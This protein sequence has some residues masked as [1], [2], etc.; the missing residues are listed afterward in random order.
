MHH[1]HHEPLI[2]HW[3]T[4]H[5]KSADSTLSLSAKFLSYYNFQSDVL[6]ASLPNKLQMRWEIKVLG[7]CGHKRQIHRDSARLGRKY[8]LFC[9]FKQNRKKFPGLSLVSLLFFCLASL[10]A[11]AYRFSAVSFSSAAV[12][13]VVVCSCSQ[14]SLYLILLYFRFWFGLRLSILLPCDRWF[15]APSKVI[16][17]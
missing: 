13:Y 12:L 11:I 16:T 7:S 2:S 14:F 15:Q 17:K 6:W 10:Y 1:L 4:P 3:K 5:K 9:Q 8:L